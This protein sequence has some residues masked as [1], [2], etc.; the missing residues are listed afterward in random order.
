MGFRLPT[1]RSGDLEFGWL[2]LPI[3][4]HSREMYIA[5]SQY[6]TSSF[7]DTS[8]HLLLFH[9]LPQRMPHLVYIPL[10]VPP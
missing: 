9:H 5:L 10:L 7:V 3:E 4:L 2:L 1:S 6:N 8:V